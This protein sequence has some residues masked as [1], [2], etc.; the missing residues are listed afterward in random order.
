MSVDEVTLSGGRETVEAGRETQQVMRDKKKRPA[1][2]PT[3]VSSHEMSCAVA[4]AIIPKHHQHLASANLAFYAQNKPIK[5]VGGKVSKANPFQKY[6][7]ELAEDGG[8]GNPLGHIWLGD[9]NREEV[10][11]IVMID[12]NAF[13]ELEQSRRFALVDHLLCRME[14]TEDEESG[15]LKWKLR[16]PDVVEFNAVAERRGAWNA[17]L[18]ELKDCLGCEPK[19]KHE[20]KAQRLNAAINDILATG[21]AAE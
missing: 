12:G 19:S 16:D 4:K 6:L 8:H 14:G 20:S 21:E 13:N 15:E 9:A 7:V 18:E 2:M 11:F 5:G 1:A 17:G 10:D 3:L